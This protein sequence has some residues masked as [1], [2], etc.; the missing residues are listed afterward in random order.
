MKRYEDWNTR[1]LKKSIRMLERWHIRMS[2]LRYIP[3]PEK[4]TKGVEGQTLADKL[5]AYKQG[6]LFEPFMQLKLMQEEL[7][8]RHGKL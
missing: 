4:E 2:R 1:D 3:V 8:K 7:D 5:T 6:Y